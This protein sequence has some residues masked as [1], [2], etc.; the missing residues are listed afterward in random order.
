[1]AKEWVSFDVPTKKRVPLL[2]GMQEKDV[3][4]E[5]VIEK[6]VTDK[7]SFEL[8]ISYVPR[9][10]WYKEITKKCLIYVNYYYEAFSSS[11]KQT[12][13]SSRKVISL[14]GCIFLI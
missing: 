8:E 7:G 4:P 5:K 3:A 1:M 14:S 11:T 12:C 10:M 6:K 13:Q 2:R 9:G